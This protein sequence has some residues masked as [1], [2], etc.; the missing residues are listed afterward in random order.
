[1]YQVKRDPCHH[2]TVHVLRGRNISKGRI[3][4]FF[5]LPDP[6]VE[7]CIHTAP[8]GRKA[9]RHVNN[10]PNPEWNETLSYLVPASDH[11]K[12]IAEISLM[13]ANF[14]ND[15]R[16][17]KVEFN[18]RN[19]PLEKTVLR[20]FSFNE[21]SDVDIEFRKHVIYDSDL[22]SSSE[23]CEDEKSF[24]K[25]RK[26][27]AF[28]AIKKLLVKH[29]YDTGG[30]LNAEGTPIISVLG[31]GGGLRAM[32]GYAG[33]MKALYDS[34]VLD[35]CTY[36]TGLS[37]S[38]W[39]LACLYAHENFPERGPA[40]VNAELR[41]LIANSPFWLLR[42]E[43]FKRY[44]HCLHSKMKAGQ[45]VTFTDLF[46]MLIGQTLLGEKK[47][48]NAKL[49]DFQE[50]IKSSDAPMPIMTCVHVRSTISAMTFHD[51]M[52]FNPFEIGIAKYGAFMNTKHFGSKFIMGVLTKK[53]DET[54]LH[55]LMGV[56]GS[57]FSILFK[58]II[59]KN[60]VS[61]EKFA[62]SNDVEQETQLDQ[63]QHADSSDDSSDEE[64]DD[65]DSDNDYAVE[66]KTFH[67]YESVSFR[68][69]SATKRCIARKQSWFPNMW[70]LLGYNNSVEQFDEVAEQSKPIKP[71]S[72]SLPNLLIESVVGSDILR[73][74]E[75]RAGKILNFMRGISLSQSSSSP[76]TFV[77][78]NSNNA[79]DEKF[80]KIHEAIDVKRK[81][82][83]LADAGLTFNSPYP[84]MLRSQRSVDI[85]LS[86]DFSERSSDYSEPFKELL[87]AEAWAKKH[88]LPF[89]KID[90]SV[91]E[92]EGM[93]ECYVFKNDDDER[94]PIIVHFVLC[95]MKFR[96]FKKTW[97][98]KSF[99]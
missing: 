59:T 25:A 48:Q 21:T 66:H 93:K 72:R 4:D 51:W 73:S 43:Y 74:R 83:H 98:P 34:G 65:T 11:R 69:S 1:M 54:P 19:I 60:N 76:S 82:I 87:L 26:L 86:F 96:W 85:I 75:Y 50:K 47:M 10:N 91:F 92:R 20:T 64:T 42:A 56:W 61:V 35:C 9:T 84:P 3:G 41:Q 90:P 13:D 53:F 2:L 5:D 39:Y 17:G 6:Y 68:Q 33:A 28:K 67:H 23:L 31:S 80:R 99:R 37:G 7:V 70:K 8:E 36:L 49:S 24:R 29:N 18:I 71:R 38:C 77:D 94:T 12:I 22:R 14:I 52:E 15:E 81:K 46:G 97:R 32:T 16:L 45:P 40:D 79:K 44:S 89:P 27:K 30:P 55:F 78:A 63:P 95:N 58:R 62:K 57:A 88:E